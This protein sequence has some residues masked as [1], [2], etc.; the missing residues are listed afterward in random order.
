MKQDAA[1]IAT[2]DIAIVGGGFAAAALLMALLRQPA[3]PRLTLHVFEPAE[4]L[5]AGLAYGAAASWHSLNI[6]AA[7]ASLLPQDADSFWRW[8]V[9]EGHSD[10]AP[11]SYLPR[12]VFGQ[13]VNSMLRQ[14]M[15][16]SPHQVEHHRQ[17]VRNIERR[18]G[19]FR[20]TLDTGAVCDSRI[21][22]LAA[23]ALPPSAPPVPG[24][25]EARAAGLVIANPWA[26]D[27][28]QRI[29]PDRP[30]F[31]LGTALTMADAVQS[32][33][34]TGHLGTITALS[35][36]GVVPTLRIDPPAA[37]APFGPEQ[38]GQG[39]SRLLQQLRQA[40]R[41]AIRQHGDNRWQA[42]IEA[43]RPITR[44]LWYALPVAEKSRFVRHLRSF[45]DAHRYRMP[46]DTATFLATEL[47]RGK[48]V[49][50]KGRLLSLRQENGELRIA[51]RRRSAVSIIEMAA[52]TLILCVGPKPSGDEAM[53]IQALE[54]GHLVRRDAFGM[55]LDAR[56]DG[57]LVGG[58]GQPV[59]GLYGL[60]PLL[61]GV[62]LECTAIAD[63]RDQAIELAATLLR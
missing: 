49:V 14:A 58:D 56:P 33:R 54:A 60:G 63:I 2:A 20:L 45:W 21:V 12:L 57:Q 28:L 9:A 13:Y 15:Q 25:T 16:A 41:A 17:A 46:P 5:G 50:E 22:V 24:L 18:A 1:K 19:G 6:T 39:F 40:S 30:V 3:S 23:G 7:R 27:E 36:H 37:T 26:L 44:P 59:A 8:A 4:R 29:P 38:A 47:N 62:H 42:V 11:H 52:A 48:L 34:Q 61:R 51:V 10:A 55:G 53:L 32:L 35:R 31:I 43:L